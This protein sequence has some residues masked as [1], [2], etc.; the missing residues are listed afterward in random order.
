MEDARRLYVARYVQGTDVELII[1]SNTLAREMARRIRDD[2]QH[3]GIV[4]RGPE[5]RLAEGAV[6][7][8]GDVI[9]ARVSDHRAGAANG[10]VLRV[11]AVNPD[12]TT[13]VRHRLH[14]H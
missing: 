9:I 3:L 10:D 12:G 2:L 11:E 1:H 7:S 5:V 4:T 6:A 13:P 8:P 14:R